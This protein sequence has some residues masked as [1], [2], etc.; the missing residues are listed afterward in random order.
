MPR[1]KRSFGCIRKLPSGR[2][3]V[4][5]TDST[6]KRVKGPHTFRAKVDAEGFLTDRRREIELGKHHPAAVRRVKVIFSDYAARWL[7]DRHVNGRPIRPRT[8][9]HYQALLDDH[10][11]PTFA[12]QSLAAITADDVKRWHAA[13]LTNRPTLRSHAYSL[14]RSVMASA[15]RD[16]L[17]ANNPCKIVGAGSAKRQKKIRPATVEELAVIADAMPERLQLMVL[18]SSWCALRFGEVIELR[19]KDIDVHGELIRVRRA[20]VR[21]NGGYEIGDPKSDAGARDVDIPPH[22]IPAIE[23]HL[24]QH[25]GTSADSLL[26]PNERGTHLQPATLSRHFYRARHEASRD[27][28]RWH[29]L[30]HTG[31]TF[32]AITGASLAELMQRL[33]HSTAQAALRYQH[34]SRSRGREI[35]ALLSKYAQNA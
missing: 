10:I 1:D 27:D 5:Y 24:A 14:L 8:R 18:L 22:I 25:V 21:V 30:R 12:S 33:G 16:E 35:A 32:A 28:L 7:C 6:G 20:A 29:D 3:Q 23:A 4:L 17:I 13:T 11:L 19:R 34:A 31:A 9:E 26:F 15:E 2:F